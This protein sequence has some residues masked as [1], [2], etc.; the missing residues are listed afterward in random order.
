LESGS[1]TAR[2]DSLIQTFTIGL[3]LVIATWWIESIV[4]RLLAPDHFHKPQ[5]W[6]LLW[7]NTLTN[8][9]ANL[10]YN[11]WHWSWLAIEILVVLAEIY[12]IALSLRMSSRKAA[13]LSVLANAASGLSGLFLEYFGI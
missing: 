7:I 8:P 4:I 5:F 2:I 12:P 13:L 3:I 10:A 9:F 11:H 6:D 1:V